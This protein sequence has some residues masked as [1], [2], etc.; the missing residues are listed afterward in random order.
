MRCN[1]PYFRC[2]YNRI[3]IILTVA[4]DT[5]CKC[6]LRDGEVEIFCDG[7]A[8]DRECGICIVQR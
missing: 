5:E 3:N 6:F 8:C 4:H 1:K 2:N 7:A